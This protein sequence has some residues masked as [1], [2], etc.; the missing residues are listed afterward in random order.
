MGRSKYNSFKASKTLWLDEIPNHWQETDLRMLYFDNKVK[1]DGL[2]E[3]NLLSLSYG[4]LKRKD[5]DS[6]TGLVPASYEGYQ[7]IEQG[8]IVLRFTD[9][10]NDKKSLRVGF[11]N[12][13]GIITSAYI[14]LA[15]KVDLHSKYYYYLL[16]YLDKIKYYYNLG[17]GVRQS[18]SFK[19]FGRETVL[20]P[21]KPEQTAIANFLDYK[22]E[23]IERFIRKKKQLLELSVERRKSLTTKIINS[24]SVQFL[25]LSF[26]ANLI[27]RPIERLDY[28][29][30]TP[31]G[32]Y[33]RGRGIFHKPM[34]LG[35][36]LGDSSFFYIKEGDVILSGQ[37]AW[38]GS[39]ALAKGSDDGCVSSHRYP[40][41]ECRPDF[42]IPEFIFSFFT[43]SNG[44]F[45]LENNS[46]GAAGRN[47]PL[48]S[49]TL[50]KEKIPVPSKSL[51]ESL[52][53]VIRSEL[54]LKK[55]INKEI[56]LVE[57]Y[58]TALIAEAVTGKIDVRD[59]EIPQVETPLAMVAEEAVNYNKEN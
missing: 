51:Q 54:F 19:D 32:L 18:L 53:E 57:K 47:R 28:N 52:I 7:I 38:E 3:R 43:T 29:N 14:G 36:D 23:K 22:L 8:N 10:Q 58:K 49:R 2:I 41:L 37:F 50:L 30:Y 35:K 55:V 46:K 40:I 20:V 17:G 25:R 16:H 26:I 5:I 44:H 4:K 33:N 12:E 24:N 27:Q 59:F 48:N 56:A 11:A 31:V 9:L 15:P 6:A 42:V 34:T 45:L 1:N 21:E 13:K 39:V